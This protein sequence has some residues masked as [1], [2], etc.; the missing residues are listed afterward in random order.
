MS[1]NK[2]GGSSNLNS[3]ILLGGGKQYGNPEIMKRAS[4]IR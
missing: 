3:S 2:Y 1:Y 4:E